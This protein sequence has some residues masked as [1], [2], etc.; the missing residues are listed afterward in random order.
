M[1][2]AVQVID[3]PCG[4]GKT[5]HA[6]DTMRRMAW[7][8]DGQF[9]YVTPFLKEIQ[10]AKHEIAD[11]KEPT[12]HNKQ[13]GLQQ[14]LEDGCN[15]AS[16]HA[17]LSLFTPKTVELIRERKVTLILDEVFQVMDPVNISKHDLEMLLHNEWLILDEDTG[18]VNACENYEE[19]SGKHKDV[20]LNAAM[21]RLVC[22]EGSLLMWLL[23]VSVFEAFDEVRVYT[24]QFDAQLQ[25]AY[26]KR[27]G[28]EFTHSHIEIQ[29]DG[30]RILKPGHCDDAAFRRRLSDLLTIYDGPENKIGEKTNSLTNGHYTNP[31]R[32]GKMTLAQKKRVAKATR[33]VLR[34]FGATG[35][36][37]I[38]TVYK[39][40]RD[41]VAPH[42]YKKGFISLNSRATNEYRDRSNM[43]YL[44]NK[45]QNPVIVRYCSSFGIDID[46]DAIALSDLIQWIMRSCLR[47]G[48]P[49]NL[50]IPSKRMRDIL[51][52]WLAV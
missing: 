4:Y 34:G 40:V 18:Q 46:E 20:V 1:N 13:E 27:F 49:A 44:I 22:I 17:L 8:L 39:E 47:E 5:T 19:Y 10:R 6:L 41:K 30:S 45:R 48:K 16:T 51:T 35:N 12:G 31:K 7:E 42:G 23:P 24:Y 11:L 32:K 9:L 43:A 38:W 33:Q 2:H 21:G 50:F 52:D 26:Y 14:M 36:D 29:E 25:A 28:V 3:A 37:T 15:I